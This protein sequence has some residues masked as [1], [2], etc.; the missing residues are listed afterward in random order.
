MTR[1]MLKGMLGLAIAACAETALAQPVA[2][3]W[4]YIQPWTP[5]RASF[6]S[7]VRSC[8]Q[9][10]PFPLIAM[11]D[12]ICGAS[13]RISRITWWGTLNTPAQAQRPF[14]IAVY[15]NTAGACVPNLQDQRF[16]A[17][18]V[19]DYVKYVGTDCQQ[20]RVYRMSAAMPATNPFVQQQGTHYWL[21]ISEADEQSVQ[22][23]V[24]NFRWSGHRDIKNCRA[25]QAPPQ[26]IQPL[27]DPCDQ[28]PDDL[29]FGLQ[30]RDIAGVI[31]PGGLVPP[32]MILELHTPTG[33]LLETLA[34]EPDD[35]GRFFLATEVPDGDYV[36]VLRGGCALEKRATIQL[37][38]GQCTMIDSF[39]DI[40]YG[41]INA[42]GGIGLTDLSLLLSGFGLATP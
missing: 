20:R 14:Y 40:F 1:W 28:Q 36:A 39:F 27:I 10:S 9:P 16:Q 31:N 26:W 8:Q 4:K 30:S 24:E 12:W 38:D 11:D 25:V 35:Q 17:C 37:Q 23:N 42:D 29:A 6:T 18:L 19:P 33:D 2:L 5:P 21:Q 22:F 15:G 13:G 34:V 7:K 41:D 32:V 3:A